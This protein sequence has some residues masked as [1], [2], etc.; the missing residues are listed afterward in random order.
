MDTS[1]VE[2]LINRAKT[3]LPAATVMAVECE[4]DK[5]GD[6]SLYALLDELQ[7]KGLQ[8]E[9]LCQEPFQPVV[10]EDRVLLRCHGCERLGS[11]PKVAGIG[12]GDTETEARQNALYALT[13]PLD[14]P[15]AHLDGYMAA[16]CWGE[17]PVSVTETACI[18]NRV[19][20]KEVTA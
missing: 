18:I 20:Y 7:Q 12:R 14:K 8:N 10:F 5:S 4:G 15:G 19:A 11:L 2:R 1:F 17:G 13:L 16:L 9:P 3:M 6:P